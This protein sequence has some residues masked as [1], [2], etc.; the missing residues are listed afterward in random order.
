MG[1][2]TFLLYEVLTFLNRLLCFWII[3]GPKTQNANSTGRSAFDPGVTHAPN[4]AD[5]PAS[6]SPEKL[7]KVAPAEGEATEEGST[8]TTTK[9]RSSR[10]KRESKFIAGQVAD[11]NLF[12]R[13]YV[14]F[15][16]F[17]TVTHP[18][19]LVRAEFRA[20]DLVSRNSSVT[21][22]LSA[23]LLSYCW[24]RLAGVD[25][26]GPIMSFYYP[27]GETSVKFMLIALI[28]EFFQDILSHVYAEVVMNYKR[29]AGMPAHHL[30][31]RFHRDTLLNPK[32]LARF[33]CA[34]LGPLWVLPFMC[35]IS[36]LF[37]ENQFFID[38]RGSS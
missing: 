35:E 23:M 21:M 30:T 15:M 34:A 32:K 2:V 6:N 3:L 26:D 28:F 19:Y 24:L 17:D 10:D 29:P 38:A 14:K 13:A 22:V 4:K 27:K 20:F 5:T 9:T 36:F 25:V 16:T 11:C 8:S 12:V 1:L 37:A 33:V 31:S 18:R 7:S